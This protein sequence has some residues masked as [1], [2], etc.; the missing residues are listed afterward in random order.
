MMD[1]SHHP[2]SIYGVITALVVFAIFIGTWWW[3]GMR[4]T[5]VRAMLRDGDAVLVDIDPPREFAARHI[6]GAVNVP[7]DVLEARVAE[8]VPHQSVVVVYG[9]DEIRAARGA[10]RLRKLGYRVINL[11]HAE[12][13]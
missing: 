13:V 4:T 2:T 3:Y 6:D 5:K 11:G 7:L 12:A 8:V 9:H 10:H 1:L